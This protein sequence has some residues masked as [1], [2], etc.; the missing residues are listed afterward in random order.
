MPKAVA[1]AGVAV[2]VL[3]MMPASHAQDGRALVQEHC[4][5]CHALGA[6]DKSGHPAAPAMKR[7]SEF[8]DLD[9]F[10]EILQA[11]RLL[12]PHPDMPA[13]KFDRARARAITNYLRSI[14]E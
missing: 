8:Y 6:S 11:G 12:A 1:A 2:W 14:Q 4:G 10:A 13:F 3:A 9:R 7:I 5:M